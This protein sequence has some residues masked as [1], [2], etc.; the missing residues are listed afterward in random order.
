MV[1]RTA[2]RCAVTALFAAFSFTNAA[3]AE[4]DEFSPV[5]VVLDSSGS[6]KARDAGGSGTR[7]DA[8]ERAVSTMV[9]G[10]PAQA[11]VGLTIYGAG[12]GSAGSD[13]AAG[14]RDV[15]VVQPVGPVNKPAL[16]AAVSADP[17]F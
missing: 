7:L 10:L 11:Q 12:T 6:M 13:K 4:A 16:K 8:A 1:R 15:R 9:D 14:C 17:P 2:C 5:M 3:A